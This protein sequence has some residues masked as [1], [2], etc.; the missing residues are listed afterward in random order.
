MIK[1][2]AVGDVLRTTCLLPPLR[3]AWPGHRLVW[4]TRSSAAPLLENNPFVDEVIVHGESALA[5]LA[6]Q[7]F[8]CVINLDAGKVS[9]RLAAMARSPRKIGFVMD[10]KGHVVPTN[11]AAEAWLQLGVF[12]D[13]KKANTQTYQ[14]RMCSIVGLAPE[15]LRYV[16]ELKPGELARAERSLREQGVDLSVPVLGIHTGGGGRW[17]LKQWHAERFVQL[18]RRL[19]ASREDDLQVVLFGGPLEKTLNE[20]LAEEL[21]DRVFDTGCD[22]SLREFAALARYCDVMLSGDSLAM[23]VALALERRVIVLFGPTS[24]AEI[25]LFGLGEKV[26]PALDCLCCYK[27]E[28][29]FVPN[30][31]DEIS[32][33]MVESAIRRQLA[34]ARRS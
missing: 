28:C 19:T 5:T 27:Q 2:D 6:V 16:L 7:D 20:R 33:E 24:S 25:E 30:C 11:G 23:H 18:V 26:L 4:I 15:G 31:M 17:R 22:N 3:E 9:S 1:L 13:L 29:D 8:D 21:R 14:Q 34:L 32:V 12:D 10:P